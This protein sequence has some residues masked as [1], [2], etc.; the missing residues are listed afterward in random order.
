[1]KDIRLLLVEDDYDTGVALK[2]WLQRLGATVTHADG[3]TEAD[4]ALERGEKFDVILSDVQMPGNARLQWVEK[5][6]QDPQ[7]PPVVLLTGNPQ[8]DTAI[9]A[10]NLPVAAY[11]VKPPDYAE[12]ASLLRRT[13]QK[14][15]QTVRL[16]AILAELDRLTGLAAPLDTPSLNGPLRELAELLDSQDQ[17]R[18]G[19]GQTDDDG[20]LRAALAEAVEVIEHTKHSFRSRELGALRQKLARLLDAD[21]GGEYSGS[22][23]ADSRR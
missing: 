23:P 8:L 5:V 1:M 17:W 4:A 20:P 18:A 13:A 12:L 3:P 11:L 9:R 6:T 14:Y 21:E 2:G 10:A 19:A 7:G 16:R 15:Q 22:S